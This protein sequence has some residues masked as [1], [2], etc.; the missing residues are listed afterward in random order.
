MHP[1]K[2]MGILP[3]K[4]K[5]AYAVSDLGITLPLS[6]ISFFLLYYYTD[7]LKMAPYLVGMAMTIAKAWDAVSDPL[8]GQISDATRSRWGRRRPYILFAAVPYALFFIM[9][10]TPAASNTEMQ[11]FIYLLAVF[12][13]FFTASTVIAIPYN[14][15]LPELTLDHHDRTR[16]AGYRQPFSIIGWIAGSAAM[17]P[18]VNALSGGQR[19]FFFTSIIF[20][21]IACIVFT[22]TFFGIKEREEFSNKESLPLI[23][24]F[25]FTFKNRAFWIFIAVYSLTSLGY[26]ILSTVLIYYAKYC[27]GSADIFPAMMGTVMGCLLLSIPFWVFLSGKIGKKE[28]FIIGILV[29]VTASILL[30]VYSGGAGASFYAIMV[31]AGI[32]TGA[33]FMF[34]FAIMPEII[35]LDELETGTRREGTYYGIFF[36]IFKLSIALAPLIVGVVLNLFGYQPDTA[37]S[38]RTLFGIRTLVG[39]IPLGLFLAGL[40]CLVTFPINRRANIEIAQKLSH[41]N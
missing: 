14:A 39:I 28:S 2:N 30:T 15:L 34:P 10:W 31:V 18:L 26:T 19:G 25:S 38:A 12:I 1:S 41:L 32:G 27:L 20:G 5:I 7:M 23:K 17:L 29:L 9:L 35:D 3:I 13:L 4:S 16:L 22:I 11:N 24:S 8:M 40:L 6:A 37:L 21:C 33:Y 36:F